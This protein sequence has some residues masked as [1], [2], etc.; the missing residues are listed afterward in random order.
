MTPDSLDILRGAGILLTG[1]S[2]SELDNLP[3]SGTTGQTRTD[4]RQSV[5]KLPEQTAN[6]KQVLKPS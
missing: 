6:K 1:P 4:G 2:V 3:G 5:V